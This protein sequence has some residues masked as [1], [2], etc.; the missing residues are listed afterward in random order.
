MRQRLSQD[1]HLRQMKR[2]VLE[3]VRVRFA[4]EERDGDILVADRGPVF[5]FKLLAQTEDSLKP[6]R[7]F[8]RITHGQTE[9]ADD[10]EGKWY[11]HS[12]NK[13]WEWQN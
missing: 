6:A 8:L 7:A 9:M 1:R 2:H 5:E 4:F 13:S 3:S 11:F 10:A 12:Q